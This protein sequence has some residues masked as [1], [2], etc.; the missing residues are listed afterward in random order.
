MGFHR[1]GYFRGIGKS[2]TPDS[3]LDN[4]F[5]TKRDLVV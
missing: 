5:E 1:S 3:Y 4:K 2:A